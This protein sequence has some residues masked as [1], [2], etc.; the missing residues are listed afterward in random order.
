MT[1]EQPQDGASDENKTEGRTR[2]MIR[3]YA[4]WQPGYMGQSIPTKQK[5]FDTIDKAEPTIKLWRKTA[6][7]VIVSEFE[8][9][10]I[11]KYVWG[12]RQKN[13][14]AP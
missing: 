10:V 14:G 12:K 5:D 2:A 9:K 6:C 8:E 1:A 11:A 7:T 3:V 4:D 13:I